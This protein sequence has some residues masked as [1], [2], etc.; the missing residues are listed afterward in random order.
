VEPIIA[1]CGLVCSQCP[2]YV[3]TQSGDRDALEAFAERARTE[4]GQTDAT[5]DATMCDGCPGTGRKIAY[6][7]AC[8]IRACA[9][10]R[11]VPHCAACA[12]YACATLE[13]F[14]ANVPEARATLEG[15]R[16]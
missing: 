4:F 15:L 9:A 10:A 11:G 14:L 8:E 13:A 5:A 2:G 3:A 16:A 6:C 7:G 1:Y 12:Q